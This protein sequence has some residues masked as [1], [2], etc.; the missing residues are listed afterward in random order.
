M[1]VW[2]SF[3]KSCSKRRQ[4]FSRKKNNALLSLKHQT[5]DNL[6]QPDIHNF[7]FTY[8]PRRQSEGISHV[9]IVHFQL[10]AMVTKFLVNSVQVQVF[11][12]FFCYCLYSRQSFVVKTTKSLMFS[13]FPHDR[14]AMYST[15]HSEH[16]LGLQ[17]VINAVLCKD[18]CCDWELRARF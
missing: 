5:E 15:G 12:F 17:Y 11:F 8:S 14:L 4:L 1:W 16:T 10:R 2:C 18:L 13:H 7:I 9:R 6:I 3:S